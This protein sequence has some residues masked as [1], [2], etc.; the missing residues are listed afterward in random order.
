MGPPSGSKGGTC[1]VTK[2]P[3]CYR[4]AQFCLLEKYLDRGETTETVVIGVICE[5]CNFEVL[6]TD[7]TERERLKEASAIWSRFES[8]DVD[9]PTAAAELDGL[10]LATLARIKDEARTW[11][12]PRCHE[13]NPVSISECWKCQYQLDLPGAE[14]LETVDPEDWED[15]S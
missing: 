11:E 3:M 10:S 15:E 6:T 12:C 14:S 1:F 8:C 7:V 9:D 4:E 2:C 13:V 5:K